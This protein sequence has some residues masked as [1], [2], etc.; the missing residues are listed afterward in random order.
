MSMACVALG[1]A[2]LA[3]GCKKEELKDTFRLNAVIEEVKGTQ[4]V[5]MEGVLPV[6]DNNDQI[7]V[8]NENCTVSITGTGSSRT[9]SIYKEEEENTY[10]AVY[11]ASYLNSGANITNPSSGISINL[12]RCQ[13]YSKTV[14]DSQIVR[15]PMIAYS[16]TTDLHFKNLC[17]VLKVRVTNSTGHPFRLDSIIV[18]SEGGKLWG[19]GTVSL[20]AG[21]YTS[22]Y[23][24]AG[25][26]VTSGGG[27]VVSLCGANETSMN[28]SFALNESKTFYIVVPMVS[29]ADTFRIRLGIEE[30]FL[31]NKKTNGKVTVPRNKLLGL[32]F[33][34]EDFEQPIDVILGPF[35]VDANGT[36]VSFSTGNLW[37]NKNDSKYYFED[38]QPDYTASINT[39]GETHISHFHWK[40]AI[41]PGYERNYNSDYTPLSSNQYLF[42]NKPGAITMANPSFTVQGVKGKF[43]CLSAA[44]WYYLL[45]T[46]RGGNNQVT[47]A[48]VNLPVWHSYLSSQYTTLGLVILPDGSTKDPTTLTD[49]TKIR[50]AGAAFLPIAGGRQDGDIYTY[51]DCW[52]HLALNTYYSLGISGNPY[53]F[54][55][56]PN[57]WGYAVYWSSDGFVP[58]NPEKAYDLNFYFLTNN[59]Y[60]NVQVGGQT[61]NSNGTRSTA[62]AIRLVCKYVAPRQ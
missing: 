44:E 25:L 62:R 19:T 51:N 24:P 28:D 50:Q 42:T 36:K 39:D 8:N 38:E 37:F 61:N 2:L 15:M 48:V 52:Y 34:A 59:P 6:W 21:N 49:T 11:P 7:R 22:S 55:P 4:K 27:N 46:R 18:K 3:T 26:S 32:A 1:I 23:T 47:Y 60:G 53:W 12:P 31:I 35:T 14:A 40:E 16:N 29:T 10:C 5:H 54:A 43:R 41:L 56:Y 45:F 58:G 9:N 30:G 13:V 33:A 20:S 57:S 17:S